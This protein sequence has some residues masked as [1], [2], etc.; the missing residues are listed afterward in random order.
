MSSTKTGFNDL[1]NFTKPSVRSK[2]Q[3]LK[4]WGKL[5]ND[6]CLTKTHKSR[7][8]YNEHVRKN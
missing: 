1:G 6:K 7:P 3:A 5:Q 2:C 8:T 4:L